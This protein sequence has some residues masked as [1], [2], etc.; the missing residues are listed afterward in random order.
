MDLL[1]WDQKEQR[2]DFPDGPV[3]KTVLPLQGPGFNI[4]L[5]N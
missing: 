2:G 1:V 4:W 5:G 3:V